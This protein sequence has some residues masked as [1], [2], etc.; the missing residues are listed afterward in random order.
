M[1]FLRT[2]FNYFLDQKKKIVDPKTVDLLKES[3]EA[4]DLQVQQPELKS[5]K[6]YG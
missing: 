2:I 3:Q 4:F 5:G 1:H 6:K